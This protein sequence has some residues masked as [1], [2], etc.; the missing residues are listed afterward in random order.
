MNSRWNLRARSV[1]RDHK[2]CF[3]RSETVASCADLIPWYL[4]LT[5]VSVPFF[6]GIYINFENWRIHNADFCISDEELV[7][8][9]NEAPEIP[10]KYLH[11]NGIQSSCPGHCAAVKFIKKIVETKGLKELNITQS[12][13]LCYVYEPWRILFSRDATLPFQIARL[14]EQIIGHSQALLRR[15]VLACPNLIALD[16]YVT[17]ENVRYLDQREYGIV[18]KLKI[19]VSS[20]LDYANCQ[21]FADS[22]AKLVGLIVENRTPVAT[23]GR[24]GLLSWRSLERML[25]S[26]IYSL[27]SLQ[28]TIPVLVKLVDLQVPPFPHVT[29]LTID[30]GGYYEDR[31]ALPL[32]RK[33]NFSYL[34]PKVTSVSVR[35]NRPTMLLEIDNNATEIRKDLT[36]N[37]KQIEL[38][39]PI[40]RITGYLVQI[41]PNITSVKLSNGCASLQSFRDMWRSWPKLEKVRIGKNL[42]LAPGTYDA[43]FCGL[44]QDEMEELQKRSTGF[45]KK[46]NLVPA[47]PAITHLSG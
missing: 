11:I 39:G 42:K 25:H 36:C 9:F 20:F 32:L 28:M 7:E 29:Q 35:S 27:R 47:Y 3:V 22:K 19:D 12:C 23:M 8:V 38:Q 26:S 43:A 5:Q 33:F 24:G 17:S 4:E 46:V 13:A 14:P 40:F 6:N 2:K 41:F 1:L 30:V 18:R 21:K 44:D 34:F 45:L 37:V 15:F 16:S 31:R 10:F